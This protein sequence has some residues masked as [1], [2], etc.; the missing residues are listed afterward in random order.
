MRNIS[1]GKKTW[2]AE[3]KRLRTA[4]QCPWRDPGA[5]QQ[6]KGNLPLPVRILVHSAAASLLSSNSLV[7]KCQQ[8]H[9]KHPPFKHSHF[10]ACALDCFYL[11]LLR[12]VKKMHEILKTSSYWVAEENTIAKP[13]FF[14][15]PICA[16][17]VY[18]D[19]R[20]LWSKSHLL[21]CVDISL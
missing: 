2:S 5:G 21:I 4:Q 1:F 16:C 13:Y 9:L 20:Y 15:S 8:W 7:V 18:F 19:H 3:A 12:K 17:L 6:D 10:L 14:F 11:G